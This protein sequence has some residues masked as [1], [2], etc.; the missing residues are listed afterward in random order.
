MDNKVYRDGVYPLFATPVASYQLG[1][2]F[3]K[4]ELSYI[5][6]C[7]QNLSPNEGNNSTSITNILHQPAMKS[8]LS[9]CSDSV[10]DYSENVQELNDGK[11][12]ITQSWINISKQGQFHHTHHHANSLWSGVLYI[13]SHETDKIVFYAKR[14]HTS[15]QLTPYNYNVFNSNSWY[16]P[17]A[18][19]NLLIF[20]SHLEHS[21]PPTKSTERISLSF[22][23]FPTTQIGSAKSLNLLDFQSTTHNQIN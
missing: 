1:R 10:Q 23:T 15:F 7:L 5:R 21:V 11:A 3:T 20:P 22:N 8:L 4:E 16:L 14:G 19:T 18:N 9:F 13:Q 12:S 2:D 6:E 17:V